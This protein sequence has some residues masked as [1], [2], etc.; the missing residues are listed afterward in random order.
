VRP[1]T[2]TPHCGEFDGIATILACYSVEGI[3][4][5]S[6]AM[7]DEPP[8]SSLPAGDPMS[9]DNESHPSGSGA[10]SIDVPLEAHVIPGRG[11]HLCALLPFLCLADI[12]HIVD[13]MSSVACQRYVWGI[14]QPAVGFAISKSGTIAT[15][16]LSWVDVATVCL[17]KKIHRSHCLTDL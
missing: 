5:D 15:L 1:R 12:D 3:G 10:A 2:T 13:L 6:L 4:K 14:P 8:N 7:V 11:R 16:I 17:R 9:V